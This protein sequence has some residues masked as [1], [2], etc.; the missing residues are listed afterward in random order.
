[1]RKTL[2]AATMWV[3]SEDYN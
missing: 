3:N 2:S 1:M